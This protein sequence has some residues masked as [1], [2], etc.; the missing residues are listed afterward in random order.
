MITNVEQLVKLLD[1]NECRSSLFYI[2]SLW[3]DCYT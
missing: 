2:Q 3:Q 1:D